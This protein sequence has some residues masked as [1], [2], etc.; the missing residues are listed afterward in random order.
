MRLRFKYKVDKSGQIWGC[1][2]N[3]KWTKVDKYGV[4]FEI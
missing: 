3:I 4:A 1:V 2:L